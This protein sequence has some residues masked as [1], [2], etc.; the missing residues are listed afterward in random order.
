MDPEVGINIVNLGLGMI[1]PAGRR[2]LRL[3]T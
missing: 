1:P 3:E 2:Q